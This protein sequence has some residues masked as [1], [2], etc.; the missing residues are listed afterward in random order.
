MSHL[1]H[2]FV[3]FWIISSVLLILLC[4]YFV[5]HVQCYYCFT[6]WLLTYIQIPVKVVSKCTPF[7]YHIFLFTAVAIP[8]VRPAVFITARQQNCG[9][10]MFSVITVCQSYCLGALPCDHYPWSIRPY[11]TPRHVQPGHVLPALPPPLYRTPAPTPSLSPV[12]LVSGWFASYRNAFL[13]YIFLSWKGRLKNSIG[14]RTSCFSS[15]NPFSL[16]LWCLRFLKGTVK[17]NVKLS[18]MFIKSSDQ[19]TDLLSLIL[20]GNNI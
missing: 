4:C 7:C 5:V 12:K 8:P 18:E 6:T 19:R 10:V 1:L 13:L 20:F 15:I 11:H 17:R 9:K 2:F 16:N 14:I 3:T